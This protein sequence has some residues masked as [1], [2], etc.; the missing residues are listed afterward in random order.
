MDM[1]DLNDLDEAE[2]ETPTVEQ[3]P[4][5]SQRPKKTKKKKPLVSAKTPST[6]SSSSSSSSSTSSEEVFERLKRDKNTEDE[7][8]NSYHEIFDT[9]MP[10]ENARDSLADLDLK[11]QERDLEVEDARLR[12]EAAFPAS[13]EHSTTKYLT[14]KL[15]SD[16]LRFRENPESPKR[17]PRPP[18]DLN[19]DPDVLNDMENSARHLATSVD[20]M[21]ESLSGVLHSISAL[22]VDTV[23][24][25]RDGVC[26]TCDEVDANT[27][28]MY[29]LMAKVEELNKSMAP[30]YAV[31]EQLKDIK[32]LLEAFEAVV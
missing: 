2:D 18:P 20:S 27:R 1:L 26:K 16:S 17:T 9:Q 29:Q 13:S 23:E 3:K 12:L 32:R 24:T 10:P 28:S 14:E 25:Y 8:S 30:A 4:F 15:V 6:S 5:P 19:L 11:E 21:I 22:T 7:M 31:G